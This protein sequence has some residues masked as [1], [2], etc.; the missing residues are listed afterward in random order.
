MEHSS[1]PASSS[2]Q[3]CGIARSTAGHADAVRGLDALRSEL[4]LADARLLEALRQRFELCGRIAQ[5]KKRHAIPVLQ[6]KRIEFVLTRV[7]A[8]AAVHGLRG[9]FVRALYE[10][11][12]QECCRHED[13]VIRRPRSF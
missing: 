5:H 1:R 9:D 3:P 7:A 4:D 8:F 11:I 2:I 12:I 10:R 13:E 6:P